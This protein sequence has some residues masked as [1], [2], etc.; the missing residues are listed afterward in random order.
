MQVHCVGCGSFCFLE[1]RAW[2]SR[3]WLTLA[4]NC[5]STHRRCG[6]GS[7]RKFLPWTSMNVGCA[8]SVENIP[9]QR[10]CTM[11]S[12]CAIGRTLHS[13]FGIRKQVSDSLCHCAV[14]VTRS[15]IRRDSSEARQ[16]SQSLRSDGSP[17]GCLKRI[18]S[19]VFSTCSPW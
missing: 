4:R 14:P 17:P 3:A 10:L 15:S 18:L 1:V 6:N 11:S 5:S 13:A 19:Y 9:G 8:N 16:R 2:I 7:E 12:I